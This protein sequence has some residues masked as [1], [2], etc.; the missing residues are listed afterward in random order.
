MAYDQTINQTT[1][2]C[3]F[4]YDCFFG[5]KNNYRTVAQN[6]NTLVQSNIA[7]V[8]LIDGRPMVFFFF[9]EKNIMQNRADVEGEEWETPQIIFTGT[10]P[11][12]LSNMEL[13]DDRPGIAFSYGGGSVW[14]I[15]RAEDETGKTWK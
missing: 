7:M 4:V 5:T 12:F 13:V 15:I 6:I 1:D 14:F 2:V 3:V 11:I 8:S 9:E 10:S